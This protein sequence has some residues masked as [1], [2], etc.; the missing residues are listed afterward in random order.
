MPTDIGL[1]KISQHDIPD[2]VSLSVP[3]THQS[4]PLP[5]IASQLAKRSRIVRSIPIG[6]ANDDD[7]DDNVYILNMQKQ[8]I[9][10]LIE[11]LA[12]STQADSTTHHRAARFAFAYRT[13]RGDGFFYI[14]TTHTHPID[15]RSALLRIKYVRKPIL[16]DRKSSHSLCCTG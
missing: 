16:D 12:V 8:S 2:C 5:S 15:L 10:E 3:P 13:S 9:T 6:T 11:F 4:H 1:I 7:D 14:Y